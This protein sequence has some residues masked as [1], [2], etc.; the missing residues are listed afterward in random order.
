MR[1]TR[2]N[3]ENKTHKDPNERPRISEPERAI[4]KEK[5]EREKNRVEG[6]GD[7]REKAKNKKVKKKKNG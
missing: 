7:E 6:K 2:L 3:Y 5:K 1:S 4:K